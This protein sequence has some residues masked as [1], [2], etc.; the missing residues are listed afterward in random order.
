[1]AFINICDQ[2]TSDNKQLSRKQIRNHLPEFS[3][4][5]EGLTGDRVIALGKS[6][7]WALKE[8]NIEHF[9]MWHP[10]RSCREWNDKDKAAQKI[11]DMF[12][13]IQK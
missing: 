10:S 1:M 11:K 6:A 12:I 2:K 13:Y 8:L 9:A 7:E 5:L 3:K 4:R